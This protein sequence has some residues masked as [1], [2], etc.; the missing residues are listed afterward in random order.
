MAE[1]SYHVGMTDRIVECLVCD[2]CGDTIEL[3]DPYYKT[4]DNE[5]HFCHSC[6]QDMEEEFEGKYLTAVNCGDGRD[7]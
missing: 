1:G 2:E 3:T 4:K 5:K 6:G 7:D